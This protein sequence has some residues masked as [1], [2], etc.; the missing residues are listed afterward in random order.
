LGGFFSDGFLVG[1]D[2]VSLFNFALGILFD[3]ILKADFDMEF[4]TTGNNVFS[5]GF[6]VTQNEWIRLGKFLKSFYEFWEVGCVFDID[7]NSY[8]WGD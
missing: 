5:G 3:E 7:G 8:N 1:N 6:G 4:T 2:W